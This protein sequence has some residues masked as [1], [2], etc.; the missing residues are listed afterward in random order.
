M[1]RTLEHWVR[2][3]ERA[4]PLDFIAPL[5]LRLYLAQILRVACVNKLIA[6]ESQVDWLV[7]TKLGLGMPFRSQLSRDGS[8]NNIRAGGTR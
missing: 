2:L 3:P 7:N 6:F 8:W 4:A 1:P 5:L